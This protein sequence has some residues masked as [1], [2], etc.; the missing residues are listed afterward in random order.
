MQVP[1][2]D[3]VQLCAGVHASAPDDPLAIL[4]SNVRGR[5]PC[6]SVGGWVNGVGG[7]MHTCTQHHIIISAGRSL[8]TTVQQGCH[9]PT[10]SSLDGS[11]PNRTPACCRNC[12]SVSSVVSV[13]ALP[14]IGTVRAGP[15]SPSPSSFLTFLGLR[16]GN[17]NTCELRA[18][19]D[20]ADYHR[21]AGCHQRA[22]SRLH[23]AR[24]VLKQDVHHEAAA[25]HGNTCLVVAIDQSPT[26]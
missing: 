9:I 14:R 18:R 25:R 20:V 15:A 7:W 6:H 5:L 11:L 19:L 23:L 2:P 21:H 13:L 22:A 8:P 4:L 16:S 3:E 17:C 12:S 10:F 26:A 1:L 24:M